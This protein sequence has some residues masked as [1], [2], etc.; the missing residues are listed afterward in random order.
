[1]VKKYKSVKR[2]ELQIP[3]LNLLSQLHQKLKASYK[4]KLQHLKFA[5]LLSNYR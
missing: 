5:Y 1:M 2:K 3:K 4:K